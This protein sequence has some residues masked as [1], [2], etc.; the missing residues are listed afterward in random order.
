VVLALVALLALL[1]LILS[2]K[3]VLH[4]WDLS[5]K[6]DVTIPRFPDAESE[7]K[8]F[9]GPNVEENKHKNHFVT[10]LSWWH[11]FSSKHNI[12]YAIAYGSALGWHRHPHLCFIPW[13]G[14]MDG[15]NLDSNY[16]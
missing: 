4:P 2:L 8:H 9:Y 13:D 11:A 15:M 14:D 3:Y 1:L 7:L 16:V 6:V 12:D 5:A 10:M